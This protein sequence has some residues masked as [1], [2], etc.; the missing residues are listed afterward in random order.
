MKYIAVDFEWNQA[1]S[2]KNTMILEDGKRFS[3]EIVQIGAVKLSENLEIESVFKS[4]I[5]PRIYTKMNS[6]VS[7]LTGITG[8]MLENAPSFSECIMK[9]VDWCEPDAVF[10]TWGIDDIRILRQNCSINGENSEFCRTWYNLQVFF[11]MQTDTG[12]N[13]KSLSAA[14]E[15]FKIDNTLKAHDALNDAY[16]TAMIAKKLDIEKGIAE[17]PGAKCALCGSDKGKTIFSGLKSR[18]AALS[19][20]EI[21]NPCC[22]VC[23]VKFTEIAPFVKA[24][25]FK[26]ISL[27]RCERHGEF[28]LRLRIGDGKDPAKNVTVYRTVRECKDSDRETYDALVAKELE[29]K[30]GKER[31]KKHNVENNTDKGDIIE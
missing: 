14:V 24:N 8:E 26:Y 17:Y 3:G 19:N 1:Q 27:A 21:C 31:R 6:K 7:E 30:L 28:V 5:K 11:N 18:R 13:Q 16:Y 25:R 23:D 9:F 10:F 12:T 15:Y 20:R 4:E 29:R 22:P 2:S